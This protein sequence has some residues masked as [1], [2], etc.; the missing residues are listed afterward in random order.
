MP[1]LRI[2]ICG[3][4]QPLQGQAIAELGADALGFICVPTSPRYVDAASLAKMTRQLPTQT[5]AG[6]ALARIGVF[7]NAELDTIVQTV[8][9]A[10]LTGV[11]LHGD[12]SPQF[13]EGVR[14]RLPGVEMIKALRVRSAQTLQGL[15]NFWPWVDTFL[16]DAYSAKGLGG[17]GQT[18]DWSLLN[19]TGFDRPWL[20]AGG[21]NP[22][23]AIAA[24]C[25]THPTGLDLSSGVEIAPGDKDLDQVQRLFQVL[26]ASGWR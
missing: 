16:L 22:E 6:H 8:E 5:T 10:A 21:I 18:W 9:L 2:K 15:S 11:Q 19:S 1:A 25:A 3:I 26:A 14:Q 24:L 13:C 12:E 7:A 23:N 20:L 17:T 4:T